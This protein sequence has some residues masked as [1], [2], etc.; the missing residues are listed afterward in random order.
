MSL[1]YFAD[2]HLG[3]TGYSSYNEHGISTAT[4]ITRIALDKI[5]ER[6]K[7]ND[8]ELLICGGDFFHTKD[9]NTENI[10]WTISWLS[11]I[12]SLNKP[13]YLI[14]GNHDV[15][16]SSHSIVFIRELKDLGLTNIKLIEAQTTVPYKD[17]TIHILPFIVNSKTTK[18]RYAASL[19]ELNKAILVMPK[20]DKNILVTHIQEAGATNG[21]EAFMIAVKCET[22]DVS[23]YK[24]FKDLTLLL[25]HIHRPQ[26]YTKNGIR[27]C[28]PGSLTFFDKS[29]CNQ[30]KG[31]VI[32]EDNGN[33]VFEPVIGIRLFKSYSIPKHTNI[34]E[35]I[36]RLR[37]SINEVVFLEIDESVEFDY[38]KIRIVFAE[39][40]CILGKIDIQKIKEEEKITTSYLTKARNPHTILKTYID[41]KDL[42]DDDK[43]KVLSKGESYVDKNFKEII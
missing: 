4:E 31:Y 9:P 19:D 1:L 34:Y 43:I 22:I 36:E 24:N 23:T 25:G 42:T 14:T 35:Y 17:Y 13:F 3:Y 26:L 11:K 28:Y 37:L 30:S 27:I 39:R 33:I 21:S 18:Y 32:L 41:T 38:E 6:A 7:Q 12:N 20:E 16:M 40:G 15:G 10:R 29:D 2:I 5:Y 8:I